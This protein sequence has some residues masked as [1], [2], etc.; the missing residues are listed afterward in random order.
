MQNTKSIFI[1]IVGLPNVGKSSILNSMIGEKVSIVSSK[2]QTTRNRIMGILTEDETQLVFIDTPGIHKPKNQLSKYMDKSINESVSSVDT[3]LLVVQAGR[4]IQKEEI[5]L[6]NKI[7]KSNICAVLAINKIDILKDKSILIN[8]I[9]EFSKLFN[10]EA[11]IPVSAKDSD[12]IYELKQELKK[13]AKPGLHL[14]DKDD[15]TDQSERTLVS[16]IIRE[17]ILHLFDKEIPHGVAVCVERMHE[18]ESSPI[19]DIDAVIYC[20]KASHKGILIGKQGA[21]LKKIGTLA[22]LDLEAFFDT[23]IN[24]KIWIKVKED[25]RNREFLLRNFGFDNKNFER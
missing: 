23:K 12:G 4:P 14:F 20:E 25:W 13:L 16:E 5:N 11:V 18:R 19:I 6:I 7:A 8:Q 22:R 2:P 9:S 3:C 17:K 24:L 15:F 1:A 21:M 10:F